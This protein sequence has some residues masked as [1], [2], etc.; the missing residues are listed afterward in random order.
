MRIS[1]VLLAVL[2][3]LAGCGRFDEVRMVD[4]RTG[5][6]A[7]CRSERFNLFTTNQAVDQVNAC[8]QELSYYGFQDEQAL[9]AAARPKQ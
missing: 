9:L 5:V 8:V 1:F 3:P 2:L 4:P 7:T 6:A